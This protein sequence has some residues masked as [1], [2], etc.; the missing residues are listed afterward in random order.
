MN[1]PARLSYLPPREREAARELD[2]SLEL[3]GP[4]RPAAPLAARPPYDPTRDP[5][6][7][8]YRDHSA[9]GAL[10]TEAPNGALGASC[11][12][13]WVWEYQT[14]DEALA[15]TAAR[16]HATTHDCE[17]GQETCPVC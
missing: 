6:S 3:S 11:P 7:P 4:Q 1:R 5:W 16:E 14:A 17:C 13:G 9:P 2:L 8:L 10:V 12:C 15:L